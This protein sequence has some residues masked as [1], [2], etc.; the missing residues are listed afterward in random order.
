MLSRVLRRDSLSQPGSRS[1][2][3]STLTDSQ[4]EWQALHLQV[5]P[6]QQDPGHKHIIALG[7]VAHFHLHKFGVP[8]TRNQYRWKLSDQQQACTEALNVS[9]EGTGD[10]VD[11]QGEQGEAV[12]AVDLCRSAYY[13]VIKFEWKVKSYSWRMTWA[14]AS[15]SLTEL[16]IELVD[17][18]TKQCL[19]CIKWNDVDIF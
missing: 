15:K 14:D 9:F 2:A 4:R 7:H 10:T 17:A 19:A 1:P 11:L 16:R 8:A 6:D 3:G 18:T 13:T 12:V 5:L